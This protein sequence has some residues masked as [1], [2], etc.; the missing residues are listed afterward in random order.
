MI[1]EYRK[2][3]KGKV[4]N[5]A[6]NRSFK[7]TEAIWLDA[8][9]PNDADLTQLGEILGFAV[10]NRHDVT[11]IELSSRLYKED[12]GY[13]MIANLLPKENGDFGPPRPV[14]FIMRKNLL[15]TIRFNEF[16]SFERVISETLADA[17]HQT[18]QTVFCNLLDEAI[19]DR[20]DDLE[21][22]MRRLEELTTRLFDHPGVKKKKKPIQSSASDELDIVL[23]RI[24]I[25]GERAADIRESI[26]SIH[27]MLNYAQAYLPESWIR[28]QHNL[29]HSMK[30]DLTALSDE[31][32]FFMNKLSFNLDATLGMINIEE[33]KIIRV[34]SVVTLLL[35]PPTLIAGIYGMNFDVMPELN[36][37]FG[38][39]FALALMA[40]TA[41]ASVWYLKK[42]MWF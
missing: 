35:S 34:L 38:Y 13:V 18:P 25:M 42:K 7:T 24:G 28:G 19:G 21:V 39:V 20:A 10:P 32:D 5:V 8:L 17:S 2:N 3:N 40:T 29:I 41:V 31:A 15:V 1:T 23:K 9:N 22:S 33:T 12:G 14:A 26:A 27:R 4:V 30:G 11:D 16:S 6:L 37:R 36:W